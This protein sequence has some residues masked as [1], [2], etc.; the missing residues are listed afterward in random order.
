MRI[1][2]PLAIADL[3]DQIS[4]GVSFEGANRAP[5][6][7]EVGILTLSAVS[8]PRLDAS[9]CKAVSAALVP[10]LGPRVRAGTILMSRS[11]T[12]DLVG[13]CVYVEED[14]VDRYL[15]DLIW[16][17]TLR[18]D[19]PCDSRWLT[20]YFRTSQG[21]RSL[22]LASA[23]T[24]KSMVKLS[25]GRLRRIRIAV[26]PRSTQEATVNVGEACTRLASA[27]R[28][29][30]TAKR[31]Q[32]RGM[33]QELLTGRRRFPEFS[34]AKRDS[35]RLGDVLTYAPRRVPKPVG[36][37]LSAGVRS[38]GKGVFLKEAFPAEAIALE[39]LFVL[40]EFDLVVNITFGWE[41]AVAI[42]PSSADGALVSHRF[43]TYEFDRTKALPEYFRHL[44]QTRRFVFDIAAASPGGA[45]R[46]RVLNRRQF[47]DIEVTLPPV[48]EQRC[49]ADVLDA[50]DR[51]IG[52]LGD[53]RQ[54]IG[55]KK[56]A[57][58]SRLLSG[59]IAVAV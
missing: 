8:G 15:P 48:E 37:F 57:L 47:L 36:H 42:V 59:E 41:G 26:P 4:A 1:Q 11:N 2:T 58:L 34:T 6:P 33:T 13:S 44:I 7:G 25:M 39:E 35:V 23:G 28:D 45:G 32:K 30:A 16:E 5:G 50:L 20:E 24:S 49:I 12:P 38:H 40:K 17:I 9:A 53:L 14:L 31:K 18:S 27:L 29:I 22:R 56:R 51:E 3:V 54:Q 52:L 21:R 43:P 46:N 55:L 10:R 19:S